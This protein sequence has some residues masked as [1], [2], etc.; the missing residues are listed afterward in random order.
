ML[1]M[2]LRK[3]AMNSGREQPHV[4]GKADQVDIV[5]TKAGD[6]VRIVFGAR[7]AF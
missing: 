5:L 3:A 7:A 1:R 4:A 6:Q 2:R